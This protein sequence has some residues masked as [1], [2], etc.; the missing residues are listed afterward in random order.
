METKETSTLSFKTIKV[1]LNDGPSIKHFWIAENDITAL[2]D[3]LISAAINNFSEQK[4]LL[5]ERLNYPER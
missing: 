2:T 3:T 4:N 5:Q 1:E